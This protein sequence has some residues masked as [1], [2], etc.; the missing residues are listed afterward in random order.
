MKQKLPK[1]CPACKNK[2][3]LI[4]VN[5]ENM[6]FRWTICCEYCWRGRW[7]ITADTEEEAINLW[8]QWEHI[9]GE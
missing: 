8:N 2:A 6:P 7:H 9:E 1:P 5:P 3:K 4:E